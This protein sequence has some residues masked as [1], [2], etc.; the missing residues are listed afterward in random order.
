[1]DP[2]DI[3]HKFLISDTYP[4]M[5]SVF[6]HTGGWSVA[7]NSACFLAYRGDMGATLEGTPT[8]PLLGPRPSKVR[9][10]SLEALREWTSKEIPQ[11]VE[12]E[13]VPTYAQGVL[14]GVNFDL[15]RFAFLLSVLPSEGELLVWPSIKMV[16][17]KSLGFEVG[18]WRGCI[19][20]V[21]G[22]SSECSNVFREKE[23]E[24]PFELLMSLESE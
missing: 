22:S 24:D 17:V 5:K 13:T 6:L 15:R 12:V 20:G 11:M 4:W 10:V 16:E 21:V 9:E 1:M 18:R 8:L 14:E 19:A 3:L 2:L 23:E 7:V